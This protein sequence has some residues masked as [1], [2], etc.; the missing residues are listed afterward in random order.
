MESEKTIHD[1]IKERMKLP[2]EVKSLI[3]L[4]ILLNMLISI[5]II[6]A[7]LIINV[8]Y[9]KV[10]VS[11]FEQYI[12]AFQMLFAIVTIIFFETAYKKDSFLISLYGI[13]MF[14]FSIAIMFV[15][16]FYIFKNM[17]NVLVIL[18]VV[19][20]IYY[21]FKSIFT[22]I[23]LRN[24]YLKYNISD[25][26]E[27][28]KDDKKAGYIDEKS[29]KT[30]RENK[31]KKEEIKNNNIKEN[32]NKKNTKVKSKDK[33]E[34][35]KDEK[36]KEEKVEKNKKN[37]KQN[38]TEENAKKEVQEDKVEAQEKTTKKEY[39]TEGL[40]ENLNKLKKMKEKKEN[41]K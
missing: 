24:D 4:N 28:V 5:I 9:S 34:V 32:T 31:T 1:V 33:E 40:N 19:F 15:P 20:T 14:I 23:Y 30:L 38:N 25:V 18:S 3:K 2:E 22:G 39:T 21:I 6:V 27:I 8:T 41:N 13:E 29:T 26:K 37:K 17:L 11:A 12:K 35:K 16:Y 7:T 10:T 36:L